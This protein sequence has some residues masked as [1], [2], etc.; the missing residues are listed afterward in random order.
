M[1]HLKTIAI[2]DFE[3]RFFETRKH[4]KKFADEILYKFQDESYAIFSCALKW[5]NILM[6][7]HYA[8]RHEGFCVG[9]WTEKL[10]DFNV[11]G[12]LG[13]VKYEYNYPEIKPRK[14]KIDDILMSNSFL[15]THT[16][17]KTWKYESE[18]RL[19]SNH[20]PKVLTLADRIVTILM[21]I[22]PK[23]FLE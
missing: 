14:A 16:K 10:K 7:S 6:W 18:F 4:S 11:F 23:S 13:K 20:F 2:K 21:I 5:N 12:K 15:E 9:L 8:N 22:L 1:L 17:A 19:T 3:R